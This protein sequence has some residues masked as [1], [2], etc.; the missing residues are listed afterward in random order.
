MHLHTKSWKIWVFDFFFL[1]KFTLKKTSKLKKENQHV[2]GWAF[3][4]LSIQIE[5]SAVLQGLYWDW[6][7]LFTNDIDSGIKCTFKFVSMHLRM[8]S[9]REIWMGSGS[10]PR[11]TSMRLNKDKRKVLHLGYRNPWCQYELGDERIEHN[12]V[13]KN[14]CRP[15]SS[16]SVSVRKKEADHLAEFVLI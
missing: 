8:M 9:S 10:G 12:S 15:G 1:D 7:S 16:L 13:E 3:S 5:M 14:L 11:W 4:W 6:C 2:N